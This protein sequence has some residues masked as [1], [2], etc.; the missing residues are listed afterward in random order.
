ME[1]GGGGKGLGK[2]HQKECF[3]KNKLVLNDSEMHNSARN[4]KQTFRLQMAVFGGTCAVSSVFSA[5]VR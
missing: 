5:N 4:C 2:Q 1:D 3:E